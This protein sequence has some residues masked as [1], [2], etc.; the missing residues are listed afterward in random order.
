[1]TEVYIVNPNTTV[2]LCHLQRDF[3]L[4]T[5]DPTGTGRGGE[6][7][8]RSVIRPSSAL[9]TGVCLFLPFRLTDALSVLPVCVCVISKLYG[10]QA[11][12]FDGEKAPRIKHRKKGT[13]S[14]V[15]NGNSQHGSQ[16]RTMHSKLPDKQTFLLVYLHRSVIRLPPPS[17]LSPWGRTWTTWMEC[18][19]C[20]GRSQ[21]AWTYWPRSTRPS[22][23]TTSSR[24]RISGE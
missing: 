1:M 22:W 14:M 21:K 6:S 8:Y 9:A 20:L 10:D 3:I 16:V 17:F 23:T 19:L 2:C 7:V 24:F 11:R 18:T 12:Y 5:G 13:V 15:N 4:Q